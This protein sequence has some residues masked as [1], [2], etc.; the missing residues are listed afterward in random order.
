[1]KVR[2]LSPAVSE[3]SEAALWYD[4]QR[5]GLGSEFW[6]KI[7]ATLQKIEQAPTRFSKSEFATLET[8]LRFAYVPRFKYVIHFLI[9]KKRFKS[10]RL[11]TPPASLGTGFSEDRVP[12]TKGD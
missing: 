3:I 10:W 5:R 2:V 1:M 9:K 8:D 6:Q 12:D 11:L 7:D 4:S